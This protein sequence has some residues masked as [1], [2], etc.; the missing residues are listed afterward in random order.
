MMNRETIR[1]GFV[2]LSAVE[3][4]GTGSGENRAM[5]AELQP[6]CA[7]NVVELTGC[8]GDVVFSMRRIHMYVVIAALKFH[9]TRSNSLA[10]IRA[11][12]DLVRV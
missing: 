11:V 10:R 3:G 12:A 7:V 4:E 5:R 8:I 1:S 2:D 9:V 6:S